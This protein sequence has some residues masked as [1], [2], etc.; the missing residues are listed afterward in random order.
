[1]RQK[2]KRTLLATTFALVV[3]ACAMTI[4]AVVSTSSVGA[5]AQTPLN[6]ANEQGELWSCSFNPFVPT[7]SPYSVGLT[8]E[9]L[10]FVDALHSGKV[11][12]WLATAYAWSNNNQSLTFTIRP[13]VNWTD[14]KPFSAADVAYT[15]NLLKKFPA[16][17]V[18]AVWSAL[19]S[20]TRKGSNQVVFNFSTPA[21]SY[22]YYVADQVPIVPEHIWSKI[23]N[24]VTAPISNPVGTGGYVMSNCTPE[25]IQWSAN[26]TYWQKGKAEVQN[27]NMP[28]FLSGTTGNQYLATG[29]SQWGSQFFPDIKANYVAKEPG[30]TFWFPPVANVSLFP[31][32]EVAPLNNV[33]VRE[34]I[35]YAIN[36]QDVSINGESGYESPASQDGVV[37]PAFSA[38]KSSAASSKI[39]AA[40]DPAKADSVLKAAGYAK[41][42]DGFFEKNGKKIKL[43]I[44]TNGGYS[45]WV[46]DVRIMAEELN[47]AGID[48]TANTLAPKTFSTDLYAGNYQMAFDAESG[49][50]TPFYEMR[51]WLYS[52]NSAPIGT[53][54]SSNWERYD[55]PTVDNLL[56]SYGVTPSAAAQKSIVDQLEIVM[57][58]EYPVI[59]ILEEV[60]WFQYNAK[61]FTGF[62]TKHNPYARPGLNSEPDWG[63]V[64]DNLKPTA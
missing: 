5:A 54:A 39:G 61:D 40:Y 18:N 45:D 21:L 43:S 22:F 9:T 42:S 60:D 6:L 15:F 36:R 27:V 46:E 53:P 20:V 29:V 10:D 56:N 31:N 4:P 59:P 37:T 25:N 64:L 32:L 24:P 30:N 19:K 28:A 7:S 16:L 35:S 47:K 23:K 44:I 62:P 51:Q 2:F 38:W 63:Y 3:S 49:G 48:A 33:A 13:G 12:P 17:D 26:A 50:P 52:K 1:V 8:Y 11:T 41:G 58:T 57:V 34:A 14:G 55:N